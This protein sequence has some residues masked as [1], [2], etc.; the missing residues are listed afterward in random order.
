MVLFDRL[1]EPEMTLAASLMPKR[2]SSRLSTGP[3]PG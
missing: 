1:F 3:T 2:R